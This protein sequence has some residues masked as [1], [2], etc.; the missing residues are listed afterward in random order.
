MAEVGIHNLAEALGGLA[1]RKVLLLGASYRED[2]KELAFSTALL[3]VDLLHKAGAEVLIHDPLFTPDELKAFEAEV[4]DL[5]S[6]AAR[7]AEAVIVQAWH[8]DFRSLD[9]RRFKHLRVVLD[10]RSAVDADR[11]REAGASY[12]AIG[13]AERRT[14]TPK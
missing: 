7:D 11:V 1:S 14:P 3:I 12:I 2:V 6:D 5:D 13:M 10:G 9:W 4:V 8:Q